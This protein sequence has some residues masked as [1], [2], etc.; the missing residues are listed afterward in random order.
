M[1]EYTDS[2]RGDY[3]NDIKDSTELENELAIYFNGTEDDAS[4]LV[5]EFNGGCDLPINDTVF[6]CDGYY[7]AGDEDGTKWCI[8]FKTDIRSFVE[9][10]DKKILKLIKDAAK[11]YKVEV[12]SVWH[13]IDMNYD[14]AYLLES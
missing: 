6:E 5:G 14:P 12:T 4:H 13:R 2:M 3:Y 8:E 7:E 1:T 9:L 11:Y 10:K